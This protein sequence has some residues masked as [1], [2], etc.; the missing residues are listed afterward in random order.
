MPFHSKVDKGDPDENPD[1]SDENPDHN[2][3]HE[4]DRKTVRRSRQAMKPVRLRYHQHHRFWRGRSLAVVVL[5][6]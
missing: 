2:Q 5:V 3:E 6:N 1:H 4:R